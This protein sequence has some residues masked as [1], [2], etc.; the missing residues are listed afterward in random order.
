VKCN[1]TSK[2][3]QK[4]RNSSGA[5]SYQC[6]VKSTKASKTRKKQFYIVERCI[7]INVCL[8]ESLVREN[9][10]KKQMN[11]KMV[12]FYTIRNAYIIQEVNPI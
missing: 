9:I 8:F 12:K 6:T 7:V 11:L 2:L 3:K 4:D 5:T 10:R 1:E